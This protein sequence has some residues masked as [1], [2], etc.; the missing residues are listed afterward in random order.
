V[1]S[2][3][4][5]VQ[6]KFVKGYKYRIYPNQEQIDLFNNTFGCTRFVY[7]AILADTIR[8]YEFYLANKGL[9]TITPA[10]KPSITGFTLVNK[11]IPLKNNPEYNWLNNISSVALQQKIF[12]LNDAFS[13]FFK[14]KKG[15][16]KFQKKNNT[17]SFRLMANSFRFK[18]NQFYIAKSKSPINIK[19][20]RSLPSIPT[21][22]TI[23]KTPSGKYYI[24]FI[25][26]YVPKKTNGNG[27][28]GI[29]LG[30]KDFI[31]DSN[32]NKILN[33]KF[34]IKYQKK[35]T[36]LQKR[37]SRKQKCSKNRNKARIV[38]AKQYEKIS[39]QRTDFLH[40]LSRKLINENQVIG[41]ERL[42]VRNMIRNRYLSKG[43][44]DAS[45]SIFTNQL[46]Y[47]THESQH[48]KLVFMDCWYPS[49]HICSHCH[50][51]LDR[52]LSLSEREWV[53][54]KCCTVHDRDTNAAINNKQE[55]LKQLS[56][57]DPQNKDIALV[58]LA[59]SYKH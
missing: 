37:L 56:I 49:T 12:D 19:W 29:D 53:C 1:I 52:K 50:E 57:F 2:K 25:C 35:L 58:I 21:S 48:N 55:A 22:A 28:I 47:K 10:I 27:I 3:D 42:K 54:P 18:N 38:V 16:P 26:E 40:K 46:I 8:E 39:N 13:K 31:V 5:D 9:N 44:A 43:I 33:P 32:G 15:Y 30:L 17:Q 24:S 23:S 34:Y 20:S 45:W 41:L 4:I 59:D 11:L 7:N 51:Q 36:K 14:N 6:S